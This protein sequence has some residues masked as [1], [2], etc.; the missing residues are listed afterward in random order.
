MPS[1]RG[2]R[3]DKIFFFG[4]Q[5]SCLSLGRQP[6]MSLGPSRYNKMWEKEV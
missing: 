2:A 4:S 1:L 6:S 5:C 3:L